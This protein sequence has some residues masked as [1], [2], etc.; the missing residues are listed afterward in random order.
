M[1]EMSCGWERFFH[2]CTYVCQGSSYLNPRGYAILHRMHHAYSDTEGDPHSP[3]L[4]KNPVRMMNHTRDLYRAIKQGTVAVEPRFEGGYPDWPALDRF[5]ERW[6]SSALWASAYTLFYAAFAT[7]WWHFLLLGAQ[8]FM[9]PTHGAI[10]NWF[11]HRLGYRNF[12]S[13]DDSRNTLVFDF[14]TCGELFQNNHHMYG[15]RPNFAVKWYEIDPAWI[16]IWAMS[17]LGIL[18][19][20]AEERARPARKV[21]PAPLDAALGDAE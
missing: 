17:K 19:I 21:T 16:G 5:G 14:V 12:D 10:V 9:G 1:F 8:L 2:L 13:A 15:S 3:R 4:H 7:E 11:G 20:R 6:L 18:K